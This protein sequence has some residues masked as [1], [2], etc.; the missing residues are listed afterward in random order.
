MS[1]ECEA[2]RLQGGASR[3][4]GGEQNASKGS[5]IDSVPLDPAYKAG[6]VGH[7]PAKA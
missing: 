2:P 3:T 4:R 1:N 5:F 6:V 7:V